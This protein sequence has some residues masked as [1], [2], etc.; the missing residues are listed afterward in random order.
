MGLSQASLPRLLEDWA[1]YR[2]R[3]LG[4]KLKGWAGCSSL[5]HNQMAETTEYPLKEFWDCS[6]LLFHWFTFRVLGYDFWAD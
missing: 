1:A 3:G 5:N 6:A 4:L 2:G